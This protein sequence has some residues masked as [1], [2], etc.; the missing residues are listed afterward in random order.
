MLEESI[1]KMRQRPKQDEDGRATGPE[2]A[3]LRISRPRK[4]E[5]D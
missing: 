1:D 5:S 2:L 3:A 4:T